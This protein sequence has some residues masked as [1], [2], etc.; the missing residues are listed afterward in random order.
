ML[1][2]ISTLHNDDKSVITVALSDGRKI[3]GELDNLDKVSVT[4]NTTNLKV[5][6]AECVVGLAMVNVQDHGN[7]TLVWRRLVNMAERCSK[8]LAKTKLQ[9]N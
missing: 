6:V 2:N 1:A 4:E 5:E 9:L 8:Q 7:D 3:V